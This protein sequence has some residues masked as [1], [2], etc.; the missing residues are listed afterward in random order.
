MAFGQLAAFCAKLQRFVPNDP[1]VATQIFGSDQILV[2]GCSNCGA[3]PQSA[4]CLSFNAYSPL[5]QLYSLTHYVRYWC[6][7]HEFGP[8]DRWFRIARAF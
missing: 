5:A 6:G 8:G 3:F 1:A 2:R 4:L 7:V